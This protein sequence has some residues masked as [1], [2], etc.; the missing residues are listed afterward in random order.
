MNSVKR[1]IDNKQKQANKRIAKKVV[2]GK[3][4]AGKD[5]KEAIEKAGYDYDAVKDRV[6]IM[7]RGNMNQTIS[8]VAQ[9]VIEGIWGEGEICKQLLIEAGYNYND[10]IREIER[11]KK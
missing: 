9:E 5:K 1:V 4:G 7:I 2:S 10:V 11:L 8:D 6:N 3:I